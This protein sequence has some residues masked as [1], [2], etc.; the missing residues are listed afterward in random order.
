LLF[1][2]SQAIRRIDQI[3]IVTEATAVEVGRDVTHDQLAGWHTR[4]DDPVFGRTGA[5]G[6][7]RRVASMQARS[8]DQ[9]HPALRHWW[10]LDP[11]RGIESGR[12]ITQVEQ[13]FSFPVGEFGMASHETP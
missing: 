2:L 5:T 7:R 1:E 12:Q 8:A 9:C 4:C 10:P 3:D 6:E 11:G 13:M